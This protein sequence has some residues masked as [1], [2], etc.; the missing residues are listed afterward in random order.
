MSL[1]VYIDFL[2]RKRWK[3]YQGTKRME[4]VGNYLEVLKAVSPRTPDEQ[5]TENQH[6]RETTIK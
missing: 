5:H 6:K 3:T 4:L 2:H 1:Q